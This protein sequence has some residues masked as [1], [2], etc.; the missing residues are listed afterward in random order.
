MC[1]LTITRV[2]TFRQSVLGEWREGGTSSSQNRAVGG[3][4]SLY[5]GRALRWIQPILTGGRGWGRACV[6]VEETELAK[7]GR[8]ASHSGGLRFRVGRKRGR[9]G[10]GL[11]C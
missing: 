11:N 1:L 5:K 6:L 7:A 3:K 8:L 4:R 10:L 9:A 2:H